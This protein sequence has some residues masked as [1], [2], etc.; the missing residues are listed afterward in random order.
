MT[1]NK[2]NTGKVQFPDGSLY[3]V[4]PKGWRRITSRPCLNAT[5]LKNHGVR[6]RMKKAGV[7][8]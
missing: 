7:A 8:V 4:T 6:R 2:L 1:K 5:N 3:G